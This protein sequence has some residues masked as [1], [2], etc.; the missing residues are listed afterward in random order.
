MDPATITSLT[1]F[2]AAGLIALLWL[3]ERRAASERERQIAEAHERLMRQRS[4]IALLVGVVRDN[5]RAMTAL[6]A[7]LRET[8]PSARAADAA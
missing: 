7:T 8:R 3:T 5:T 6:E 1:P 4:E 2:G